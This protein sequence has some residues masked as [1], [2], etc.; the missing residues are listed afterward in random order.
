MTVHSCAQHGPVGQLFPNRHS[1]S[2]MCFVTELLPSLDTDDITDAAVAHVSYQTQH[3][4]DAFVTGLSCGHKYDDM[5]HVTTRYEYKIILILFVFLGALR[6]R[7]VSCPVLSVCNVGVLWP[8]GWKD[9]DA[10][11]YQGRPRPRPYCVRWRPSTPPHG[12]ANRTLPTHTHIHIFGPCLLWP[13]GRP[14]QELL[15][16][17]LQF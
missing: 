15:S 6:Y 5:R 9:Q 8:N 2:P 10:T 13:N 12:K 14:S 4:N 17:C 3:M 11:W 16:S 7:T 1:E